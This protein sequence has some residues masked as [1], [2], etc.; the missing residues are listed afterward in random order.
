MFMKENVI[1]YVR[2]KKNTPVGVL[3][4]QNTGMMSPDDFPVV[5]IGWSK[6][7]KTDTFTKVFGKEIA[8]KRAIK[9][10]KWASEVL[11][12]IDLSIMVSL[13]DESFVSNTANV[14]YAIKDNLDYYLSK[15]KDRLGVTTDSVMFI[16]PIMDKFVDIT[17]VL[18][19]GVSSNDTDLTLDT[20]RLKTTTRTRYLP[21]IH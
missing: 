19:K 21:I 18:M 12:T 17:N 13:G 15:A 7:N 14:P 9:A 5:V 1:M 11:P 8:T 6:A 3:Y 2:N 4:F 16:M 20:S 10:Q